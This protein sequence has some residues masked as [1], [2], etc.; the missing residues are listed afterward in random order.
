MA[1]D[2]VSVGTH[3]AVGAII[4]GLA[5]GAAVVAA[6]V[7]LPAIGLGAL[8]VAGVTLLNGLP[9]AGAAIGGYL[10]YKNGKSKQ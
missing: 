9:W 8:G 3:T 2:A 1:D 5:A 6:P 10:G 7:L 4:G